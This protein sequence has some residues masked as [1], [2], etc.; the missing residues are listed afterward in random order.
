[1]SHPINPANL[2]SILA[3]LS[4]IFF[5][6][7]CLSGGHAL[8][9]C[10]FSNISNGTFA[11]PE[12]HQG[13]LEAADAIGGAGTSATVTIHCTESSQ[14]SSATVEHLSSPTGFNSAAA[15]TRAI[16][17]YPVGNQLLNIGDSGFSAGSGNWSQTSTANFTLPTQTDALLD[18]SLTVGFDDY[19]VLPAGTY[20]YRVTLTVTAN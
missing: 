20:Q 12:F 14:I 7:L 1:M 10:T 2:Q 18:I 19:R 11:Q 17:R 6:G 8:A 9:N 13:W 16:I 5:A 15:N 3:P 4:S